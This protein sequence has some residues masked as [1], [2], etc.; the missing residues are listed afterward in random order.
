MP[1]CT[2][3]FTFLSFSVLLEDIIDSVNRV[4]EAADGV[5]VIKSFDKEGNVLTHINLAPP[6]SIVKLRLVINKVGGKDLGSY[7][8]AVFFFLLS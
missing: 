7:H 6:L 8:G 4:K 5:I 2:R 3:W 1:K